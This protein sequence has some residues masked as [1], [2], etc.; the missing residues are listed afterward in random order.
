MTEEKITEKLGAM[1]TERVI[2]LWNE[3]IEA[4]DMSDDRVY[5]NGEDFFDTYFNS[6][7]EAVLSAKLGDWRDCDVYVAFDG[8]ANVVS[9]DYWDDENSPIDVYI[10]TNWLLENPEKAAE[11]GIEDDDEDDEEG[12]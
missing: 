3:C 9:F 8:Y 11:Y 7:Y 4:K 2:E 12:E 5:E 10:L 1:D 6:P